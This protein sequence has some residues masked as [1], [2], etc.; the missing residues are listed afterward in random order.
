[1]SSLRRK[2]LIWFV[3]AVACLQVLPPIPARAA[4]QPTLAQRINEV[5]T[6]PDYRQATWAMLVIDAATGEVVYEHNADTLILPASV[7]KL[8]S[9]AA[10]L[11][12]LGVGFI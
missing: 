5:I 10:A 11:T 4:Q 9:V 3:V 6:G 8:F 2:S 1:M 12:A 7:T